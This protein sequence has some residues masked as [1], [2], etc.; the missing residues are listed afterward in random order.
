MGRVDGKVVVVTGAAG[1]QGAAEA[2]ALAREGASV[3][4][5]D[6][7]ERA[8]TEQAGVVYRPAHGGTKSLSDNLRRE[9]VTA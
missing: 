4:A 8:P 7:H 1:G 2:A 3:V 5:T 6:L 9:G